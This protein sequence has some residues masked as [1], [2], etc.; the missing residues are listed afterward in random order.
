MPGGFTYPE[1]GAT[2]HD[3]LPGGYRY[4][5]QRGVVG[6]GERAFAAVSE[7][8]LRFDVHRGAFRRVTVDRD[9]AEPG[10]RVAG[11]VGPFSTP[12]EVVY[13]VEEERRRGFAYGTLTGNPVSGEE[14]FDVTLT[15]GGDVVF[16][17]WS[18]SRAVGVY[19]LVRPLTW[20]AQ[21]TA[22]RRYLLSARR[23]AS[24]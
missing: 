12:C 11:H 24:P 5:G 18:F 10:A 1:V 22:N 2:R 15:D 13:L 21:A 23:A 6:H 9:R 14:L 4:N 3:P 7:A 17:L 16:R 20:A 19:G 8:L